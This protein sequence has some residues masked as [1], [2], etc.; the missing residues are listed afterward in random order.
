MIET[1][2]VDL[3]VETKGYGSISYAREE[4]TEEQIDELIWRIE[5]MANETRWAIEE[6]EAREAEEADEDDEEEDE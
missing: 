5:E 6:E 1:R 4:L 2:Q 3:V